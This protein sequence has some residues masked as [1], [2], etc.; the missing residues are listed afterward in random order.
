MKTKRLCP[1]C[2]KLMQTKD[3]EE[4]EDGILKIIECE[5]CGYVEARFKYKEGGGWIA[6]PVL[7]PFG[8][9]G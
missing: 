5:V 3:Y 2:K 7:R 6:C 8:N 9:S 4:R 1:T